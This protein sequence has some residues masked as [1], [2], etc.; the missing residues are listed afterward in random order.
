VNTFHHV[1]ERRPQ[2]YFPQAGHL[3]HEP[4]EEEI[5]KRAAEVRSRWSQHEWLS[6]GYT[7]GPGRVASGIKVIELGPF[8]AKA[9]GE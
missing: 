3:P 5:Q 1:R 9:I 6:R 8:A 2:S 7:P 4:S